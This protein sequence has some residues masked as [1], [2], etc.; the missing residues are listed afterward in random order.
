MGEGHRQ[1]GSLKGRCWARQE[2]GEAWQGSDVACVE[3][4]PAVL[5]SVG[6]RAWGPTLARAHTVSPRTGHWQE[7]EGGTGKGSF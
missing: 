7:S 6:M 1:P 3:L 2:E 5:G 4:H